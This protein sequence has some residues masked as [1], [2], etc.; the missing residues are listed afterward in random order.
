ML[1]GHLET[2]ARNEELQERQG[3]G[4]CEGRQGRDE[5]AGQSEGKGDGSCI[6]YLCVW[7]VRRLEM[8]YPKI[9]TRT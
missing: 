8:T 2:A 5:S 9:A 7:V 4:A 1:R 6:K 3:E